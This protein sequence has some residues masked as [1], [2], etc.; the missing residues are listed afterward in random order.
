MRKILS[1]RL[2]NSA[3][4]LSVVPGFGAPPPTVFKDAK[5]N[6]YVHAGVTAG[7]RLNVDLL[8]APLTRKIRAGYC[9]Q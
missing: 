3:I 2:G 1:V 8:S 7:S 4:T 6:V 9:G 5:G